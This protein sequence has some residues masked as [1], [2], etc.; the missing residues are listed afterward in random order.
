MQLLIA[1]RTAGGPVIGEMI[2]GPGERA[3]LR[4]TACDDDVRQASRSDL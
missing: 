2:Q 4:Y 3:F 1:A